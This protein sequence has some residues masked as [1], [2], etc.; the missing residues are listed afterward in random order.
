MPPPSGRSGEHFTAQV[1]NDEHGD[2]LISATYYRLMSFV[3]CKTKID[4]FIEFCHSVYAHTA[5]VTTLRAWT[6]QSEALS[7]ALHDMDAIPGITVGGYHHTWIERAVR[8]YR[9]AA[10]GQQVVIPFALFFAAHCC[11]HCCPIAT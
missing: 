4:N 9:K 7:H 6:R 11:T 5:R 10:E 2:V 8:L 1:N 3:H